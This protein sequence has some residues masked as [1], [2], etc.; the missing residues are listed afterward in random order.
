MG[1]K[2]SAGLQQTAITTVAGDV[3]T[4]AIGELLGTTAVRARIYDLVMGHASAPADTA[5]RWEVARATTSATGT[6]AVEVSLDTDGPDAECLVEEE[7][8]VGPTVTAD[9]QLLDMDLNQ[10]ATFR[11]IAAPDAEFMVPASATGAIF[12]N[13]SSATY[14]G[15]ARITVMWE[16]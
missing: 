8:T 2:Y 12:F 14:T 1:D 13:A 4:D 10:R 11:W 16:E 15:I 5:I 9:N 6:A 7:V 3:G